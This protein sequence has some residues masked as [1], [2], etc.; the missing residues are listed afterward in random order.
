MTVFPLVTLSTLGLCAVVVAIIYLGEGDVIV[1]FAAIGTA[2]GCFLA[3]AVV[4]MWRKT[5][6]NT[7]AMVNEMREQTALL[8]RIAPADA[9]EAAGESE[10][11]QA[12]G[13]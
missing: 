13:A 7:S 8:R 9:A 10:S 2:L 4:D 5:A 12:E 1:G 3:A 11:E 6:E